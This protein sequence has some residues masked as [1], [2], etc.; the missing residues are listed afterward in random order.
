MYMVNVDNAK[1]E[2]CKECVDI[3]PN[4]VFQMT[5]EKSTP[6]A[7]GECVFCESCIGVC[8]STAITIN[9]M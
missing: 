6:D 9:E 3:C 1:C 5:G 7:G 2:G 8:P 4:G